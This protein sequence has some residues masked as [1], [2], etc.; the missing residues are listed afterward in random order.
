[1]S[2]CA[3]ARLSE[4]IFGAVTRPECSYLLLAPC[5]ANERMRALARSTPLRSARVARQHHAQ[6][7]AA[8]ARKVHHSGCLAEAYGVYDV[9]FERYNRLVAPIVDG[10]RIVV[11]LTMPLYSIEDV[12]GAALFIFNTQ[13]E[14]YVMPAYRACYPRVRR[15]SVWRQSH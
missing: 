13:I 1:M 10:R 7:V 3:R 11:N 9:L 6:P 12:V 14:S 2:A 8:S 15:T 4:D 5:V